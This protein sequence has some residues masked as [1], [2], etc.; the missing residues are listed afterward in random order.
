MTGVFILPFM[1]GPTLDQSENTYFYLVS[2]RI[3]PVFSSSK[4]CL[5]IGAIK[6]FSITPGVK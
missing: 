2:T 6:N 3:L 5:Q 1:E 4:L